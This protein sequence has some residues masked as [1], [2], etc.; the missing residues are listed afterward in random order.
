MTR[1]RSIDKKIMSHF[2]FKFSV[3]FQHNFF[4]KNIKIIEILIGQRFMSRDLYM[5]YHGGDK[6]HHLL[7]KPH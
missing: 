1:I 6:L 5:T 4:H 3:G 2:E 7:L